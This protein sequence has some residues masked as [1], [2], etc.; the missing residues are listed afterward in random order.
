MLPTLSLMSR[1]LEVKLSITGT[2]LIISFLAGADGQQVQAQTPPGNGSVVSIPSWVPIYP[3][4]NVSAVTSV[5][6][7]VESMISFK[8]LTGDSCERV[9]SFYEERLNLAGFSV[10]K[11]GPDRDRCIHVLQSHNPAGTRK[12]NLSGG[13]LIQERGGKPVQMTRYEVEVIQLRDTGESGGPNSEAGQNT[14][15]VNG[16][17]PPWVPAYP[18]AV[19]QNFSERKSGRERSVSF[20]IT[21]RDDART[22][23]SWY[24]DKL[25]QTGFTVT[26][27][28]AGTAGALRSNTR[29]NSRALKIEVSAA[30]SQNVALF[31]VRE[32][33]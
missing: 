23:L 9:V 29:D 18:R 14:N 17:I 24:Q 12:V 7:R 16:P 10:V 2:L 15:T 11:S 5:P 13:I 6:G 28:V 3:A 33:R 8:I 30:G 20:T 4:A 21:T 19:P 32:Q 31:E 22:I 1:K 25:R 27:D 26:M